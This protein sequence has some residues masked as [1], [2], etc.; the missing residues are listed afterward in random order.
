M[1]ETAVAVELVGVTKKFGSVVATNDVSIGIKKGETTALL[2]PSGCGKTTILR[3]IAGFEQPTSGSLRIAGQ[4]VGGSRP[5]ERS[6]GIL[7]QQYALF[8]H[9][10][11]WD[12][13]GYGLRRRGWK[14]PEIAE[15]VLEMLRLVRLENMARRWPSELSGGQQQRVALARALATRPSI[16]LLD[17]PLS[18]LDAQLRQTLRVELKE[19]LGAVSATV[20]LVTHDQ[21]EAMTFAD[22]ILVMQAGRIEQEGSS[23]DLYFRPKTRF[24]AEF[25]GKS[26]WIDGVS[27]VDRGPV[28]DTFRS[29][30]GT[31]I[32]IPTSQA[33]QADVCIRPERIELVS[34]NAGDEQAILLSGTVREAVH[35]GADIHVLI[36]TVEGPFTVF[37]RSRDNRTILPGAPAHLLIHA[38]D[39]MLLPPEGRQ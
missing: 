1:Q 32:K 12:N 28:V 8:P 24:V 35:A 31:I 23:P 7:F 21:E 34:A 19:I 33:M 6:V 10:T 25:L 2:G 29:A 22:R 14:R 36:D 3:M 37:E 38:N 15:R 18:A 13:I 30:A 5:Y 27:L 26:N 39:C 9:M 11:V 17:E 16:V 4:E 20:L